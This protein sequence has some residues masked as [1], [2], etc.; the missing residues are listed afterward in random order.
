MTW[1]TDHRNVFG[2]E[3]ALVS[4]QMLNVFQ[5]SFVSYVPVLLSRGKEQALSLLKF[6]SLPP[7]FAC[8]CSEAAQ[9]IRLATIQALRLSAEPRVQPICAFQ[10]MQDPVCRS[11]SKGFAYSK[12]ALLYSDQQYTYCAYVTLQID[13]CYQVGDPRCY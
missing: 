5:H 7:L 1:I 10:I 2:M 4:C 3:R 9:K 13:H 12:N 11:T 6:I 8:L